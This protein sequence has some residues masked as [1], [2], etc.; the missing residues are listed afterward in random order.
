[1]ITKL[2]GNYVAMATVAVVTATVWVIAVG[3]AI[4]MAIVIIYNF[5]VVLLPALIET[6]GR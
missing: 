4:A 2:K 3:F 5:G 1:M 6:V